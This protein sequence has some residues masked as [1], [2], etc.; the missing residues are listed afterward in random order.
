MSSAE[1]AQRCSQPTAPAMLYVYQDVFRVQEARE[2]FLTTLSA[3]SIWALLLFGTSDF[4][5]KYYPSLS[6]CVIDAWIG[7]RISEE[8]YALITEVRQAMY[9]CVGKKYHYPNDAQNNRTLE[10]VQQIC[11]ALLKAPIVSAA[12]PSQDAELWSP[13]QAATQQL[14]DTGSIVDP[15]TFARSAN[16]YTTSITSLKDQE[17]QNSWGSGESQYNEGDDGEETD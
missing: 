13:T 12:S 6:V 17:D 3:V 8:T 16:F 5:V 11:T 4:L 14:S 2:E 15:L 9:N 7:L 10:L 1:N